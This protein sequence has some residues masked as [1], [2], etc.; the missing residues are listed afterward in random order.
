MKIYLIFILITLFIFN[1]SIAQ[2][3]N[4]TP[5]EKITMAVIKGDTD[6]IKNAIKNGADV[7]TI[8]QEGASLLILA[9]QG[10]VINETEASEIVALLLKNGTYVNAKNNF[11]L[12]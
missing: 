10:L 2:Y 3:E 12:L 9:T 8:D 11:S 1:K 4:L 7:N 5:T 6:A